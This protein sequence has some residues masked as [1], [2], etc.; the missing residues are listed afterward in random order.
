[1]SYILMFYFTEK[2]L[3]K[4]VQYFIDSACAGHNNRMLYIINYELLFL[5]SFVS[6]FMHRH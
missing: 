3:F 4:L 5:Q 6:L 1:M 2:I